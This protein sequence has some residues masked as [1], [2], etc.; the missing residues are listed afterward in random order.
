MKVREQLRRNAVALISLVIAITSLGYNTWRNEASE[1][2]RNQRLVAIE[3]LVMLGDLQKVILDVGHG[4]GDE[5]ERQRNLREGWA[6][7]RT[8]VDISMVAD[9]DIPQSAAALFESWEKHA[10]R[11]RGDQKAQNILEA[12]VD[13]VR[14]ATHDVLLSLD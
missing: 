12:A 14:K 6:L 4:R 1:N 2:N 3:T 9:G 8:L 10:N 13:D 11:F 7:A 5:E